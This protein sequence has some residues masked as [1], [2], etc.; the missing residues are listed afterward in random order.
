MNPLKNKGNNSDR[1]PYTTGSSLGWSPDF[2]DL[3][4]KQLG[5][6]GT[7]PRFELRESLPLASD[8]QADTSPAGGYI[9]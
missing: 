5:K 3:L 1:P 7:E 2:H 6:E 4:I 9:A 8:A